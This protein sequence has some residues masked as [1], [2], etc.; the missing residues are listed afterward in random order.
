MS[1]NKKFSGNQQNFQNSVPIKLS[2]VAPLTVL[3]KL[4]TQ[5]SP[6]YH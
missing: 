3:I 5:T 4:R 6:W 1:G 2:L